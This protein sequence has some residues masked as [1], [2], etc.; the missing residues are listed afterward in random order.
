MLGVERGPHGALGG[1]HDL[2]RELIGNPG[3]AADPIEPGRHD[4]D[5]LDVGT[6]GQRRTPMNI[7]FNAS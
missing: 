3:G 5:R 4:D 2:G 7:P 1:R 6:H